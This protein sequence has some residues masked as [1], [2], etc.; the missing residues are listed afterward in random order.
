M[1]ETQVIIEPVEQKL[2]TLTAAGADQDEVLAARLETSQIYLPVKPLC[3]ALAS[4]GRANAR[5][6]WRTRC[7]PRVRARCA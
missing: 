6:S 3:T 1:S 2:V 4:I 5:R 7:W